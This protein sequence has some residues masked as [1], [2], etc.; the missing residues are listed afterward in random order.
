MHRT[1]RVLATIATLVLIVQ[2]AP[3]SAATIDDASGWCGSGPTVGDIVQAKHRLLE[4]QRRREERP[5][6]KAGPLIQP[7]SAPQVS[8][9]GDVVIVVDDG[10]II[11]PPNPSDAAGKGYRIQRKRKNFKLTKKPG[12]VSGGRGERLSLGDDDSVRVPFEKGFKFK[13]FGKTY[14]AAYVNSDGN[15]TFDEGDSASTARDL[16]RTLSGPARI[17]AY[18]TDLDPSVA[19][20]VYVKFV[21]GGKMQV[22][23]DGVPIFGGTAP[24]TFQ[25]TLLKKGHVEFRFGELDSATGIIGI[26]PG[27]GASVELLDFSKEA[28]AKLPQQAIAEVFGAEELVDESL[29]AKVFYDHYPDDVQQLALFYDF[30]LLLLGGQ[31]V[32]YHFTVK[33]S[34]RGIGYKHRSPRELFDNSAALGSKGVLEGFANMGYVSKYAN[35]AQLRGTLSNLGVFLHEIGHQWLARIFYRKGGQASGGLQENGGHWAFVTD[36]NASIMQGNEIQDNGDGSFTTLER[37]ENFN[38]MDL[39]LMGMIPPE[40]VEDMFWVEGSGQQ[41]AQ[42]PQFFV[43][44]SGTR[45][46]VSIDDVIREEGRRDPSSDDAPKT[47]RIAMILLVREGQSPRPPS[48]DKVQEIVTKSK[49]EWSRQTDGIGEFDFTLAPL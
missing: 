30:P 32:A 43:S 13:F 18:F 7:A 20:D 11:Q 4:R 41:A 10:S 37:E 42:L 44:F 28:P 40:Q 27:G 6:A 12:G 49:R 29:L 47:T 45:N 22:T 9:Q 38:T 5:A 33:N 34:V 36:T 25:V 23:W 2:P 15:I 26:S 8:Q 31:A 48:I 35:L 19:G 16:G 21:S 3:G 1:T 24:N 46:D 17:M 39:Y 14:S